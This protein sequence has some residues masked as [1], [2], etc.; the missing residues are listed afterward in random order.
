M[1]IRNGKFKNK[2]DRINEFLDDGEHKDDIS[3]S[4][5]QKYKHYMNLP[6]DKMLARVQQLGWNKH[7]KVRKK[8]RERERKGG[9][10]KYQK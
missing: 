7:P 8:R 5:R 9:E 4:F 6:R 10:Q 1:K 2:Q 3:R